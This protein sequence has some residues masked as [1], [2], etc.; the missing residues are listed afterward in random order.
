MPSTKRT[1]PALALAGL[2]LAAGPTPALADAGAPHDGPDRAAL[3]AAIAARPGDPTA[4]V[5]ARVTIDGHT[6][7]GTADDPVS[8][9]PVAPDAAFRIGSINKTFVATVLLQLA[10]EQ[11]ISLDGTVQQYLPGVLPDGVLPD[12]SPGPAYQPITVRQLLDHTSGLPQAAEGPGQV[13]NDEMIARRFDV[14]T[15]DQVVQKTLRPTTRSWPEPAFAPG[16][17]QQ[18][19]NFNYRLA[20]LLI[21]RVTGHPLRQE[22]TTRILA[23]LHLRHTELTDGAPEMPEPHLNGYLLNGL[24]VPTDVSEQGGNSESMVSTPADLDRFLR[25]LLG[26][27][28]LPP[29]QMHD[30]LTLPRDASG[31]L[32]PYD[33]SGDC[34]LGPDKGRAC[35]SAG[36][37]ALPLQDGTVLWGKTGHDLGYSDGIFATADLRK[38]LVYSVGFSNGTPA[39]ALRL[40]AVTFGPFAP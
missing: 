1:A 26:G 15:F 14:E 34:Q 36:L 12:G 40:A 8:G 6:W 30:L 21:E 11:R 31:R 38:R 39:P 2:L 29:Q 5:V 27:G 20:G 10:A 24:H 17:E 25:A 4:G 28:L 3:S 33:G 19:N 9:Q 16:T 13:P 23:P 22:V 32:L 37:L 35:Y 18:Y 7:R